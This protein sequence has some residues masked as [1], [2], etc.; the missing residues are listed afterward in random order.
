MRRCRLRAGAGWSNAGAIALR[1][2]LL[3]PLEA[4]RVEHD[5]RAEVRGELDRLAR[6]FKV[7]TLVVLRRMHDAGSLRGDAY[8]AAYE[9]ELGRLRDIPMGERRR[10]ST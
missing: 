5:R 3:V 2:R 1:Q 9:Q 7:S 8:W 10:I 4:F 6:R